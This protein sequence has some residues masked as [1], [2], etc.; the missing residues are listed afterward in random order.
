ME[1]DKEPTNFIVEEKIDNENVELPFYR[2]P[3]AF[4]VFLYFI[5]TVSK[6]ELRN[7]IPKSHIWSLAKWAVSRTVFFSSANYRFEISETE[8]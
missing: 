4:L 2:Y 3:E 7:E 5:R 1:N 6:S 8:D